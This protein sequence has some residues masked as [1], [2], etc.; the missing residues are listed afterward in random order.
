MQRTARACS[1]KRPYAEVV[2]DNSDSDRLHL[3]TPTL[4]TIQERDYLPRT[5]STGWPRAK[6]FRVKGT[7][8][9][10]QG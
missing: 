6:G 4:T 10:F 7:G 3:T 8:F 9:R 1:N 2:S 5:G